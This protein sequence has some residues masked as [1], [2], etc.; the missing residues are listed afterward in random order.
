[1]GANI[2]HQLC[3]KYAA[4]P[5]GDYKPFNTDCRFI[6]QL[7]SSKYIGRP[8]YLQLRATDSSGNLIAGRPMYISS[9]YEPRTEA[10]IGN[11]EVERKRYELIADEAGNISIQPLP[12]RKHPSGGNGKVL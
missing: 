1:M 9:I 5:E 6:L 12:Y 7:R 4:T 8:K 3:G 10:G 11:I 2:H